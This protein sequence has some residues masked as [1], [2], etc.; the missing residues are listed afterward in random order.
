M[1]EQYKHLPHYAEIIKVFGKEPK[2][3]EELGT[4]IVAVIEKHV[5]GYLRG[6][7]MDVTYSPQIS[8]SHRCPVGGQTNWGRRDPKA[9]T[10]YP[11]Y[12]GRIWFR[13]SSYGK[14]E[15]SDV[16]S[17]YGRLHTAT[18]GS[19]GYG[20]PWEKILEKVSSFRRFFNRDAFAK[21]YP[22]VFSYG[23]E[24][25][26]DD[27]PALKN[28]MDKSNTY[29]MLKYSRIMKS[30]HK[31]SW[32]DPAT[33]ALDNEF[34]AMV[35]SY[36]PKQRIFGIV[37]LIGSGK[38]TV[39]NHIVSTYKFEERS[40]AASVKSAVCSIFGYNASDIA[41][42]TEKSRAWR[43]QVDEWWSARLGIP[44]LTP[45][46]ILQLFG[47]NIMRNHFHDD[48][49]IASLEKKLLNETN[50]IVISDVRFENEIECIRRMGG[51]IIR[52]KRDDPVWLADAYAVNNNLPN[53]E[54]ALKNLEHVHPS[55]YG[56]VGSDIDYTIDNCGTVQD[57][58]NSVDDLMMEIF[59]NK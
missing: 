27:F 8:N 35:K 12:T 40:F 54:E 17:K 46:K 29:D 58:K 47:T 14:C 22:S 32:I 39:A 23:L 4:A 5:P 1:N 51:I 24:I 33:T 10:S 59:T 45:R 18:G 3:F 19:G 28:E 36:K 56:W 43:E 34:L 52:V 30:P 37:G 6:L 49:W 53:R 42:I 9:P 7:V 41:G 44:D 25:F 11:G 50:N 38:S 13:T 2:T 57:L 15:G 26:I 16:L 55:E 20:G 31:F 21:Y 48:I